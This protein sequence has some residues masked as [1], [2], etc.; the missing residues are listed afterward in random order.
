MASL[1]Q[2]PAGSSRRQQHRS[3]QLSSPDLLGSSPE[4]GEFESARAN[5]RDTYSGDPPRSSFHHDH[6]PGN[7]EIDLLGDEPLAT[8][9][10]MP[11]PPD[12][13][14]LGIQLPPRPTEIS[15]DYVPPF[16]SPRRL[17]QVF[18]FTGPGSPPQV[19]A[20]E[21]DILFHSTS[22]QGNKGAYSSRLSTYQ[23]LDQRGTATK[24]D[25]LVASSPAHTKLF[26]TLATTKLGS[27]WKSALDHGASSI[28]RIQPPVTHK[29]TLHS[30]LDSEHGQ[31]TTALHIDINHTTPFMSSETVV[32][33]Y[34][35]PSGAPGFKP[36][37]KSIPTTSAA[38]EDWSGTRLLERRETTAHVLTN[39]DA[40][41]V[42][43]LLSPRK[44]T[45]IPFSCVPSYL[46]DSGCRN[47]GPLSVR[48]ECDAPLMMRSFIGSARRVA[49][50]IIPI[51]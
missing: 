41:K 33:S 28:A 7:G 42:R 8:V 30:S 39:T 27:K 46:Q 20:V 31:N 22:S 40:D 51:I 4:F 15:P 47:D 13:K 2:P 36:E 26:N 11:W 37:T 21:G 49:F 23:E 6:P 1:P 44:L 14:P 48:I 29:T 24:D 5:I 38:P 35:P 9:Q 34:I 3:P 19:S 45:L 10:S 32:G 25:S 43:T 18:S 16:R 17:S 50:D 12:H